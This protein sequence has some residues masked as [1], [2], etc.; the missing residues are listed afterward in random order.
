MVLKNHIAKQN[1]ATKKRAYVPFLKIKIF[2]LNSLLRS[3]SFGILELCLIR[4]LC[5][6]NSLSLLPKLS[7]KNSSD[8]RFLTPSGHLSIRFPFSTSGINFTIFIL[9]LFLYPIPFVQMCQ[10]KVIYFFYEIL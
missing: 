6:L 7:S 4:N 5:K 2:Y 9:L 10:I 3:K 8:E 1:F